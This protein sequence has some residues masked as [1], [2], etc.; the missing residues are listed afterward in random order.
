MADAVKWKS[1]LKTSWGKLVLGRVGGRPQGRVNGSG[2]LGQQW[3]TSVNI[4]CTASVA[5]RV[6]QTLTKCRC[7]YAAIEVAEAGCR[8]RGTLCW[9]SLLPLR[10]LLMLPPLLQSSS[11]AA[12]ACCT[13]FHAISVGMFG[14]GLPVFRDSQL[15]LHI[16]ALDCDL[17]S[18]TS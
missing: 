9:R 7:S 8:N 2:S 15:I 10:E 14:H 3:P 12:A 4:T 5:A 16:T 17:Q 1:I 13:T 18:L 6:R 11:K